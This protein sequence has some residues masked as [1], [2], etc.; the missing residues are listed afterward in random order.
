MNNPLWS[1]VSLEKIEA[2]WIKLLGYPPTAL[3]ESE[4]R[5]VAHTGLAD[6]HGA[7]LFYRNGCLVSVPEAQ[8]EKFSKRLSGR[9]ALDVFNLATVS[10]IFAEEV[11]DLIPP[12]WQG[13]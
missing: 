5:V 9:L 11:A 6:Y 3:Q 2:Y 7:Y 4:V 1:S 12:A 13:Y 8:T 10:Q